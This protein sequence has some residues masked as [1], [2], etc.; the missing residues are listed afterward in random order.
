MIPQGTNNP[1]VI[2][3]DASIEN[4]PK[5]VITLWRD[6]PGYSSKLLKTWEL[7]DMDV[8]GD[9][10]ICPFTEMETRNFPAAPLIIE[11]KGLDLEGNIIFWDEYPID[12]KRRRDK[13]ITLTQVGA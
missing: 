4:I 12:V 5:L 6:S 11:A 7:P 13:I 10:A 2:Q 1:L 9:T 8:S 3:F